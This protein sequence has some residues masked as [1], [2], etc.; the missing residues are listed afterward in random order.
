MTHRFAFRQAIVCLFWVLTFAAIPIWIRS[1]TPAWDLHVYTSAQRELQAG[2]DPYADAIAVQQAFH[3]Q[4]ALHPNDPPP[5]TYVY[6]PI[7]LPLLRAA[8]AFPGWF[9]GSVYWLLYVAG[10]LSMI[11]VGMQAATPDEQRFFVFI[12]PAAIFFPGLMVQD[13]LLSG[14]VVYILYGL[15]FAAALA[16][17]RRGEWRWFYLTVL[18]A[19]CFKAPLLSLLP[20][21]VLSARRQWLPACVTGV[22]GI[23][24]FAIQPILWPALFHSYLK[25]IELQFSYNQDF[26]FSPAGLLGY[27]L[28]HFGVPYS[29]ATTI[30]YAIYAV[31][32]FSVLFHLSRQ[33]LA[34]R[35]SLQQWMP[36]MLLGVI[37]LNPRVMIY[38]A[39]P[40]TIPMAL[41]AWRFF[42][43]RTSVAKALFWLTLFFALVN[44][45]ALAS[46]AIVAGSSSDKLLAWKITDGL[47]LIV[48]FAAGCRDLLLLCS[49][50]QAEAVPSI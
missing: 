10:I 19:S 18:I 23:A 41:I 34:G 38:D 49:K 27:A 13:N 48:L 22:A 33:F 36:V 5:Y 29:P 26:G 35:F 14:N 20:I 43:S 24:L 17:W 12:A 42:T 1:D 16:G 11:R 21:P 50:T 30:F 28:T 37:L 8:S 3:S 2:D 4:I 7:T 9:S 25:A 44:C 32:V 6:S 45:I 39:V 31:V 46:P 47:L 40:L 15:I